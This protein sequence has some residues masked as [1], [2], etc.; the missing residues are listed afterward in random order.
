[1][2]LVIRDMVI[3]DIDSTCRL[4]EDVIIE[5]YKINNIKSNDLSEFITEKKVSV[6]FSPS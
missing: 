4:L 5:T 3:A 6:Q 2:Q 1:M